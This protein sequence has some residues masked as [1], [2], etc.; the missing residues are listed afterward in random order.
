MISGSE[1]KASC[2]MW[3]QG[4]EKVGN[5]FHAVIGSHMAWDT[6]LGKDVEKRVVQLLRCDGMVSRNEGDCLEI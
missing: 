2:P 4:L 5:I 6:M 3:F 1:V